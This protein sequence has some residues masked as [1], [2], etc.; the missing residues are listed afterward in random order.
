M[1]HEGLFAQCLETLPR[2]L[3]AILRRQQASGPEEGRKELAPR[4]NA[5]GCPPHTPA[6]TERGI[7]T[8]H[9]Q[10]LAK[11]KP[12]F[13]RQGAQDCGE[14]WLR[15]SLCCSGRTCH[16]TAPPSARVCTGSPGP[17]WDFKGN[18]CVWGESSLAQS[19]DR[20]FLHTPI[21]HV[22]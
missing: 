22:G 5:T 19:P 9:I 10:C 13:G 4:G 12:V 11:E 16:H 1:S 2:C 18:W 8:S 15:N 14:V 3:V 20:V 6:K 17:S 21:H 7:S